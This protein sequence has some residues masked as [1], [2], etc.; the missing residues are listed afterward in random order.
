MALMDLQG[1]TE[2]RQMLWRKSKLMWMHVYHKYI[3]QAEWFVRA[4]DGALSDKTKSLIF[5]YK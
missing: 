2:D 4:D 3:T 5:V 1:D